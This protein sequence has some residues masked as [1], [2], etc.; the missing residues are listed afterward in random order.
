M[1]PQLLKLIKIKPILCELYNDC[2]FAG[3]RDG[4]KPVL[5]I[6]ANIGLS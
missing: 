4:S 3:C 2:R 1:I 6:V 5:Y